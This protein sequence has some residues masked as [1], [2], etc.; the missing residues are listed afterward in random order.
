MPLPNAQE[1]FT[2][3][4]ELGTCAAF[5]QTWLALSMIQGGPLQNPG[6]VQNQGLMKKVQASGS[7]APSTNALKDAG[8][9]IKHC[10]VLANKPWSAIFLALAGY[11]DGY[12]Y[13]T[14]KKPTHA[15]ACCVKGGHFYYLEPQVGCYRYDDRSKLAGNLPGWYLRQTGSPGNSEFK[16]YTVTS[17]VD[18]STR[19]GP[20]IGAHRL[21]FARLGGA[22]WR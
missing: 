21:R 16:I 2:T 10:L 15:N 8:L 3:N 22:S 4:N 17:M 12:Y 6:I 19:P 20:K 1:I 9:A 18:L 11:P 14:M 13:I 5:S 7:G